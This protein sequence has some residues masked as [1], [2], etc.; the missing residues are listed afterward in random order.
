MNTIYKLVW[1]AA[2]GKYVVASELAKGRKKA[3]RKTLVGALAIAL[4]ASAPF[5][6]AFAADAAT[7][8]T[9]SD[10]QSGTLDA[11][12]VCT[13][14]TIGVMS[15]GGIGIMATGDYAAGGGSAS[16]GGTSVTAATAIGDSATATGSAATA[17]GASSSAVGTG[18][19][20]L[21][22]NA[23]ASANYALAIGAATGAGNAASASGSLSIAVGTMSKATADNAIAIGSNSSGTAG[24]Q[25]NAANGVAIGSLANVASTANNSVALGYNSSATAANA[26]ALGS[27]AVADRANT[28]SVGSDVAG[29]A[30]TTQ[31]VNVGNGTEANDAVNVSQLSPVVS[32]LGGGASIDPTTGAVTGPTYNINGNSYSDVGSALTATN[33]YFKVSGLNNGTDDAVVSGPYSVAVGSNAQTSGQ[34]TTALGANSTAS[35]GNSTA[36]GWS[37][38]ATGFGATALG[39][40]SNAT[41]QGALAIT[42]SLSQG[43]AFATNSIA[44]G[45]NL[46][47]WQESDIAIGTGTNVNSGGGVGIGAGV[48]VTGASSTAIGQSASTTADNTVALGANSV[49]DRANTVSVGNDGTTGTAFTSQIVNVGAGTQANDA[50]NVS[51]LSPVVSALGG[52]ASIDP[53]TGAVTGPTYTLANGG[54]QTTVAGAMGAL[55]SALTTTNDNVATN[56]SN[57]TNLQGQLTEISDGTVGLVQQASAGANLTVGANTDGTTVDFTGTAGTRTLTGVTAGD[58]SAA[59]TDA[60]NGSQLFATNQNVSTNTANIAA[61]TANIAANTSNIASNSSDI[62]SIQSSL[63]ELSDGTVGLVQQTAPGANLT[64]GVNTDGAAVDFTGTAGARTLTGVANGTVSTTSQDAVNGSQL[65]GVSDSVASALGGGS[66]VNADGSIS[67]PSY[68]VG[69]TTVNSI[70]DAITNVDGRVT[71]NEGSISTLQQQVSNG[72]VGLVQQNATT[73]NITVASATGGSAVDFTGTSGARVLTGVANGTN[74]TDAVTIA[75]LKAV[76][77]VDPEGQLLSALTY[78]DLSL[79]TATLGGT[80]GTVINNLAPG[81]IA[82]GSMQAVNG[83]QLFDM[84]Q[85]FQSQFSLLNGQYA[86]LDGRVT[87]IEQG[88]ADGTVGGGGSGGVSPG[89]GD[90]STQV[91]D[92]AIASGENGT[93]VGNGSVASGD[94]STTTG[95]GSQATGSNS[96]ANGS[97]SVASGS[98]S[99]AT[100]ANSVASGNNSTANGANAVASGNGSTAVGQSASAT[101]TNSTA[102]GSNSSATGNNSVA[103]GAGSVADRDN[104]VSVGSPGNNRQITN[105]AAGT[106][107]TDAVN[108]GQL[109]GVQDW[110]NRKFQQQDRR[111]SRIGAMGAAY[112][113]MAF[114]AQGIDTPNKVG[115]GVGTQGGQAAIA[116][117]YSRQI[118]P[119]VHVSF[120]GSAS[121]SDVSVGAGMSMGW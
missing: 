82:S 24:T 100:G 3:G 4:A 53:T 22:N 92:G 15:S 19:T 49:A 72:S 93:A 80:N 39:G 44:I 105:V 52:G 9:T 113:Q 8:C 87:T 2:I 16:G 37:A 79:S 107:P 119:N 98:N 91:G 47:A 73:G 78:D 67:T 21:G 120:G 74:N 56:S 17:Y 13:V 25:S 7:A 114:S 46:A 29:S 6:A 5:G 18:A 58:L 84:Q 11:S 116:V 10:G 1:S 12:G 70:G 89:T 111:I 86:S 118:K 33:R 34:F 48:N 28:V 66:T 35:T 40:G 83:G 115:V 31:I 64:V 55:D 109:Q 81:L 108:L 23:D 77:V 110:A 71:T 88:I 27:G 62:T 103:L 32:A 36:L 106:Q 104:T 61:N 42:S 117:G 57:I 50:V 59:S 38:T 90:N 68:T 14:D 30:F 65:Y 60:V 102:M 112:G 121:G 76:G 95:T 43:F 20:A 26:F 97:G 75:Q 63:T 101:G 51:Q 99:T 69:G 41:G 94:N 85:N 45:Q 96:T 54:T